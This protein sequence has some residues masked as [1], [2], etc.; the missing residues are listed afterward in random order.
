M[1]L[2]FRFR[3]IAA[4]VVDGSLTQL[5]VAPVM[6]NLDASGGRSDYYKTPNGNVDVTGQ[7]FIWTTNL[8]GS[9]VDAFIAKIP[10]NSSNDYPPHRG[11]RKPLPSRCEVVYDDVGSDGEVMWQRCSGSAPAVSKRSSISP[12]ECM[13]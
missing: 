12:S 10:A 4:L 13:P 7:Y 9:R 2:C 6:M 3:R 1:L 5:V 8:G 11:G